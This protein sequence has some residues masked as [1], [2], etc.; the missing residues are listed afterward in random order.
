MNEGKKD[1]SCLVALVLGILEKSADCLRPAAAA[2]K[3]AAMA[4]LG[5]RRLNFGATST[6]IW[7]IVS[8]STVTFG[9]SG[10]STWKYQFLY[11]H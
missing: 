7:S 5:T 3:T 10:L 8:I 1:F 9:R 2:Q 11:D 6:N 4:F